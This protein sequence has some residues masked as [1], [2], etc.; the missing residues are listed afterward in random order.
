MIRLFGALDDP[1]A[2]SHVIEENWKHAYRNIV[3]QAYL[4]ALPAGK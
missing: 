3:P 1:L 4:D 2:V